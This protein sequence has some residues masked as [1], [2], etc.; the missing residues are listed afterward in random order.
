MLI[1]LLQKIEVW[2]IVKFE[3]PI[4]ADFDGA[5]INESGIVSGAA[6]MT[7]LMFEI[8]LGEPEK[9]SYYLNEF[10]RRRKEK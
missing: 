4:N 1:S 5:E 8:T 2:W 9:A 3:I 6:L 7:Q 10:K